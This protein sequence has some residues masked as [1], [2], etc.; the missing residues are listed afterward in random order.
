MKK[1]HVDY[2]QYTNSIR[3]LIVLLFFIL[4]LDLTI[5]LIHVIAQQ[6]QNIWACI[7]AC[8]LAKSVANWKVLS[9]FIL[10]HFSNF[11]ANKAN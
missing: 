11:S 10:V 8:S 7:V 6:I 4:R 3:D 9:N 2:K 5:G 1:K